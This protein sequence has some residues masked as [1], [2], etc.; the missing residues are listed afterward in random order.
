MDDPTYRFGA[1]VLQ[2]AQRR[3]L[4]D[5]ASVDIGPRAFDILCA[6]VERPGELLRKDWLLDAVWRGAVVEEANLHV[7]V[8]QLRK[9]IGGAAFHAQ[10]PVL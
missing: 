1:F 5:G 9:V 2:P 10:R 4:R 3:L 6:L 8:S 7:Q